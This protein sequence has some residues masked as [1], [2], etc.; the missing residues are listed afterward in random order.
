MK[1]ELESD[2]HGA[3]VKTHK[4]YEEFCDFLNMT[5][6][7]VNKYSKE[8]EFKQSK[9][10][11]ETATTEDDYLT[12]VRKQN[13]DLDYGAILEKVQQ[14]KNVNDDRLE[15]IHY[16]LV[17]MKGELQNT[18]K[19]LGEQKSLLTNIDKRMEDRIKDVEFIDSQM[20]Q[21]EK[22][23]CLSECWL[24]TIFGILFT[25]IVFMIIL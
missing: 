18:E 6:S 24:Y 23:A 11:V 9:S 2:K 16:M 21:W 8:V 13:H 22:A 15:Q 7:D 20:D 17:N 19:E 4:R 5:D 10:Y 12:R 25:V 14:T 1:A 3:A